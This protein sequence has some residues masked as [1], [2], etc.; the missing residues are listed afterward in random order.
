MKTNIFK[1]IKRSVLLLGISASLVFC[2]DA[3]LEEVPKDFLSPENAFKDPKGFENA[4]VGVYDRARVF[5]EGNWEQYMLFGNYTDYA[6]SYNAKNYSAQTSTYG[7]GMK[8]WNYAYTLLRNAQLIISRAENEDVDWD[9]ETQKKEIIAEGRFFRAWGHRLLAHMFGG[10]PIIKE[11]ISSPK[12]DFVRASRQDVYLFCKEDLEYAVE[13]LP[14]AEKAPGRV[15]KAAACHLL[16]EVNL[17]LQDWDG[18]IE[19]ASLV[20]DAPIYELMTERFGRRTDVEGDV[21][22]DLHQR[23]NTNRDAGNKETIW[24]IQFQYGVKGGGNG[25]YWEGMWG[26]RLEKIKDPNGDRGFK[27]DNQYGRPIAHFSPTYWLQQKVWEDDWDDMRNSTYNI[28]R[29]YRYNNKNSAYYGEKVSKDIVLGMSQNYRF[30]QCFYM[31]ACQEWDHEGS[32]NGRNYKDVYAMRLAETYLLRAEAYLGKGDKDNAAADINV[33]RAR[34]N[35]TPVTPADVDMDYLLDERARELAVEEMRTLTL[36]RLGL[37]YDRVKKNSYT[38]WADGSVT[39]TL[40]NETI[41]PHNNLLPI[42]QSAID[43]NSGAVLEQNPGY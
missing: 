39:P 19:A 41:E 28:R 6:F 22:W 37:L 11:E 5:W 33:V 7:N 23:G 12:T 38:L 17:C 25:T 30:C 29:E 42:P 18:A 9:S 16:A 34:A 20:I 31:K 3:Y 24:A 10:V 35:A 21:Y 1:F 4:M 14:L 13:N 2:D 40:G 26:P 32:Y 36:T 43:L 27:N 15:T 8:N